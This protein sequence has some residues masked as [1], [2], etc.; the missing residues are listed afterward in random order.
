MCGPKDTAQRQAQQ[1]E[2]E[3]RRQI[4]VATAAIDR[5]FSGRG[6]QLADFANALRANFM[7]EI[8]DQKADADRRLKFA[9][10]RG[11]QTGGSL[12][13]D[14]GRQLGEEFQEGLLKGESK[15]QQSVADLGAAD[16][17]SRQNLLALAQGGAGMSS[18]AQNAAAALR[19][20]LDSAK[21]FGLAEDLGDVFSDTRKL[22]VRQEEA[23]A[24]RRGLQ[25]S[26]IFADPFSR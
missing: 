16:E 4:A 26:E 10:T 24:R 14:S 3:R 19:Q 2:D 22:F 18:S 7:S 15:V 9:L 8:T 11:G 1:A 5:A 13:R 17:R 20:N 23:A 6:G 25:E 21:A 12:A